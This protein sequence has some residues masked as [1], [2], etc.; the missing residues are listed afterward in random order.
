MH[1]NKQLHIAILKQKR[2]MNH[3]KGI[4]A[5][6]RAEREKMDRGMGA[7]IRLTYRRGVRG[8]WRYIKGK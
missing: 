2:E 7:C 1:S 8:L 5:Q 3:G 6:A 4:E